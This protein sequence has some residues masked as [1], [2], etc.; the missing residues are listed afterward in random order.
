MTEV[1]SYTP[2]EARPE[3][4]RSDLER[5][6]LIAHIGRVFARNYQI[7]VMPSGQKGVW[8]TVLNDDAAKE[9]DRY[10]AGERPTIDDIP[11]DLFKPSAIVY[12]EE[13]ARDMDM[14]EIMALLHHEA[15]HA[16]YTDFR[17]MIKGQKIAKDQGYL[18]SSFWTMFEGLEDPRV[19][20]LEGEESPAIDR[21]I[22]SA[23]E[24]MMERNLTK[25]PLKQFSSMVQFL[26]NTH[27]IWLK[28]EPIQELEGT[29]VGR[30]TSTTRPLIDQY[31]KSLDPVERE[32]L[33][34]QIWDI[35][36]ELEKKEIEQEK[37]REMIRRQNQGGEQAQSGEG[38]SGEQQMGMPQSGQ[39]ES[40]QMDQQNQQSFEG[41]Q[42]GG[43]EFSSSQK[44]QGKEQERKGLLE[45][46]RKA[47]FGDKDGK[48]SGDQGVDRQKTRE[49]PDLSGLT[50]EQKQDLQRQIDGL[51]PEEKGQLERQVKRNLDE[52]QMRFLEEQNKIRESFRIQRNERTGEYEAVPQ[53]ISEHNQ[54]RQRENLH[55]II[56][57]IDAQEETER[58][59]GER[60]R[61]L[62]EVQRKEDE[63]ARRE[64]I[65]MQR[66]GFRE[67]EREKYLL[68]QALEDSM[69]GHIRRFKQAIEKV[70]P[71]RKEGRYEG[72]YFSGPKFDRR[73]LIRKAPVGN[74][75]F[76]MRQVDVPTG[77]PRLFIGLLVDNSGSMDGSKMENARKTMIFF[78]K[79]CRDMGIPF[80]AVSFGQE[81]TVIK[82]F[83]QDFDDP[84]ERIKPNMIDFTDASS[85][86]TNLHDGMRVTIEAMNDERRR[87][88]D[89]HGLIF[90]I[91]DGQ[92]NIGLT[93]R[94]LKRYIED[95]KGR[96]TFKGFGLAEQGE[97][98]DV[99]SLMNGYF[100]EGNS[101][102]PRTFDE[103][104][105][106][107]FRLLR[108]N[109]IQ[110]QRFL[111]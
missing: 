48:S 102:Y 109:F 6:R 33:L 106:E 108:I 57:E 16:K 84:A 107:A 103:L 17:G 52:D 62:Q 75:Q 70:I 19:N 60:I 26:Y 86:G 14:N 27:N 91:S 53:E 63:K 77:D 71:R 45:K 87:L 78:A 15:G 79:V 74:E 76:H 67:N 31:F 35:A 8:A 85:G 90:I 73:D 29:D 98:R 93:G 10:I 34:L 39:G 47:L 101:V 50:P 58:V 43:Q 61:I 11:R 69:A 9:A 65:E 41:K 51:S 59:E 72:G 96:N 88:H 68:Y 99:R 56:S 12:D 5:Y 54:R 81:A 3:A 55:R 66:D 13:G 80:M 82:S 7:D 89:S 104:P 21:Q 42:S 32:R 30:V 22:R 111:S 100:G 24:R 4:R 64:K 83:R 40:G 105:D 38:A 94:E 23:H 1:T 25:T 28:G 2:P 97:R 18:P 20:S 36:K 49:K 46:L 92:A 37:T 95:N 44:G 110:F